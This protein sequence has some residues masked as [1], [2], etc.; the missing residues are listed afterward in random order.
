VVFFPIDTIVHSRAWKAQIPYLA[1]FYRVVV[2]DPRGNGRSDR[3]TDPMAYRDDEFVAD[4]IAVMD[5]VGVDRAVLVGI[6]T[7]AW[8]SAL[9]AAD[10]PE[11]VSGLFAIAP[12]LAFVTPPHPIRGDAPKTF[13]DVLPVYEGWAKFNQHYWLQDWRGFVEFFFDQLLPEPHSTKQWEDVVGFALDTDGPTLVAESEAPMR[14]NTG[15]DV[16]ALL[17]TVSCPVL[18]VH[19]DRDHCQPQRRAEIFAELTGGRFVSLDGAGHLPMAREPVVVNH[20]LREFIEGLAPVQSPARWTRP[21][22]RP[23]KLLMVSS[24]IGL[25][26]TRRDLAIVEELRTLRP[27]VQVD[28]LAQAPVSDVAAARGETIHP[29]S[30]HLASEVGH[31]ESQAAEHDLHAFQAIRQMDEILVN[32]FMVFDEL[33]REE[34][35]DAWVADEGWDVD[36]FLHEN[37]ELKS[38][39]Y[40]WLTDFVGWLPMPAGGDPE[41]RLT[42][43]YNAEMVEQVARFP[44]L[45]DRSLFVG[46]PEDC[47]SDGLGD[48][49]PSVRAWTESHFDFTGY[50]TGY[51]PLSDEDRLEAREQLGWRPD[52]KVVVVAVGGTSVGEP[53]LRRAIAA[54]PAAAAAVPGLRMVVVAGP[55]IDPARLGA[56]AGVEVH[57]FIPDLYKVLAASD[58]GLVQGGL[59]TCMELV[60]NRRPFLYV[61]LRNH[62]EQNFHVAHRLDRYGAGRRLDYDETAPEPLAAAI[63]AEIG[64]P[65]SYAPV[66]TDGAARAAA[67]IAELI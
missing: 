41:R 26:H 58:L 31:F 5:E 11:R 55:R 67:R 37:P 4:T 36:Y 42:T 27:E 40:A 3:P 7:S 53:L 61:P 21:L 16:E 22:D 20:L 30:A 1:R 56:P 25:G 34:Q 64:R 14:C 43:D 44:R 52:E 9:L 62:F 47:V 33:V 23:H 50:V 2:I 59:T 46:D 17:R 13:H 63:A 51:Q 54:Y 39:A 49:L 29:A 24:P 32:N 35:Y 48:G 28:W 45:R 6:C 65:V 66:A 12:W 8:Y 57:G 18:S 60:A 15:E 19:G 38:T 10:H